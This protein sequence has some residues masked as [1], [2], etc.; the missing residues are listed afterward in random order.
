LTSPAHESHARALLAAR[1]AAS[2]SGSDIAVFDVEAILH[3]IDCFVLVSA[4]NTRMVRTIVDEVESVL[5]AHDGSR[6]RA[7]EGLNDAT[8][9]LMDYGDILVHV[10]LAE[11]RA[12][13]DL[14]RLWADAGRIPFEDR[15]VAAAP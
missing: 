8:W 13:Y 2:K 12:Y 1:A 3:I 11:T 14:D 15:S 4:T 7:V 10:F 5:A 6:P 9:V